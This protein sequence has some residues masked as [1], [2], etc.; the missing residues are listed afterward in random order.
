[1]PKRAQRLAAANTT[2]LAFLAP[3][4]ESAPTHKNVARSDGGPSRINGS[5]PGTHVA[6]NGVAG[7]AKSGDPLHI[8]IVERPHAW[9]A[10]CLEYGVIARGRN[11]KEA[12]KAVYETLDAYFT[13][14]KRLGFDE[15]DSL[16][17]AAP[18]HWQCFNELDEGD[19]HPV[20]IAVPGIPRPV[21]QVRVAPRHPQG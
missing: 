8:L 21:A 7:R 5:H 18:E 19:T 2:G 20:P 15:R 10:R 14:N 9:I 11:A 13:S 1:M 12:E 4:Q 16:R 6:R 3:V 17:E